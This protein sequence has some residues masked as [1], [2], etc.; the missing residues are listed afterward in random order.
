MLNAENNIISKV[1]EVSLY[2]LDSDGQ[3]V[4]SHSTQVIAAKEIIQTSD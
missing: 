4:F 2:R 3:F 1:M